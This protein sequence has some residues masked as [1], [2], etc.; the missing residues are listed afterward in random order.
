[1]LDEGRTKLVACGFLDPLDA[2][3]LQVRLPARFLRRHAGAQALVHLLLDVEADLFVETAFE[4]LDSRERSQTPPALLDPA[5]DGL[6][7]RHRGFEPLVD[8]AAGAAPLRHRGL[9]FASSL[10]GQ[11][12]VP[13]APAV[14]GDLPLGS[15][16]PLALQP[17]EG[18]VERAF[19][20]L[21]DI[22]R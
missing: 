11:G 14:L 18:G 4:R 16:E 13:A 21:Q 12:V 19:T 3:E 10:T 20:E 8:G 22:P 17:V 2:A 7:L 5:H 9:E 6:L 1:I 15:D